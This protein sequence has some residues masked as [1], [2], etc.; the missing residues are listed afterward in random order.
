MELYSQN[1]LFIT[2]STNLSKIPD[3]I[4]SR[5]FNIRCP[6][7]EKKILTKFL[8]KFMKDINIDTYTAYDL[9]KLVT[10][11][12]L[13]F[14]KILLKLNNDNYFTITNNN[15]ICNNTFMDDISEISDS[16]SIDNDPIKYVNMLENKIKKHLT[17]LKKTKNLLS[18]ISKNREFIYNITYFNYNN[19]EILEKF[20]N[21]ILSKYSE[22]INFYNIIKITSDTDANMLKC[23]RDVFHYEKY[24]L[25]IYKLF[26]N[27]NIN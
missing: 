26:H 12:D 4:K 2:I 16:M 13:D 20:V 11:C 3:S 23:N 15:K 14:N 8:K 1:V 18:V 22:Q 21:I 5:C 6:I 7:I 17:Y 10:N 25:N 19:Q 9:N 27:H 24:L